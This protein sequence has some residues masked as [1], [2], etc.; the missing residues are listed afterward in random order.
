[1]RKSGEHSEVVG[2]LHLQ[3]RMSTAS[4]AKSTFIHTDLCGDE[5]GIIQYIAAQPMIESTYRCTDGSPFCQGLS[6]S[7]SFLSLSVAL[8]VRLSGST[9]YLTQYVPDL[10]ARQVIGVISEQVATEIIKY[11]E[12]LREFAMSV[13]S[14]SFL[15]RQCSHPK[16]KT[17][18]GSIHAVSLLPIYYGFLLETN[19]F[20]Y[21]LIIRKRKGN[22][23]Q[24]IQTCTRY[25]HN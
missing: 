22:Y 11:P 23:K 16:A 9:F 24:A 14:C 7:H 1:M 21:H 17:E 19:V 8:C 10:C 4:N 20:V 15:P 13:V 12:V 18:L 25:Y 3:F 5:S 2:R 6:S